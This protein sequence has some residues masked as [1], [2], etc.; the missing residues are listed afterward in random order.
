MQIA[1]ETE[2]L[3]VL[4]QLEPPRHHLGKVL[5]AA[6]ETPKS[7]SRFP[8]R[9]CAWWFWNA[10]KKTD[11]CV[12]PLVQGLWGLRGMFSGLSLYSS[13]EM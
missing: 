2:F 12:L 6:G 10:C 1:A 8:K 9:N 13:P 5:S 3:T 11:F 4:E 7:R